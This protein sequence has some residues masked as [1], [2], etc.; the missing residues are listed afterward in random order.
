V[1]AEPTACAVRAVGRADLVPGG[2][3][4]VLGAGPIG[5]LLLEVLRNRGMGTLLF[6]ERLAGRVPAA[7]AAGAVRLPDEP[8]ALVDQ[9]RAATAG[10]GADTVF[11]AVGSTET[12]QAAVAAA[13]PGGAVCFVGLHTA[14]SPLPVRD[15]VRREITTTTSFAYRPADFAEALELL[16]TG[17]VRFRGDV[18]R[19]GLEDGQHWYEQLVAGHPAGKVVLE[20]GRGDR[21]AAAAGPAA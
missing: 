17:R 5:L 1:L 9:V 8:A 7:E 6:T 10:L 14:E 21:M 18:V 3:A 15:L 13:R 19:A 4:L 2:T 16:G 20:P 11:D 12:R